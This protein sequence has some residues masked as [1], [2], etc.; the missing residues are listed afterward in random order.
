VTANAVRRLFAGRHAP[1]VALAFVLVMAA[2]C[3]LFVAVRTPA[4]EANDE[5][6]HTKNIQKLVDG[7]WYR[8]EPEAGYA[9]HQPPLYYLLA[10]G[11]QR[12]AGQAAYVAKPQQGDGLTTNGIFGHEQP[13]EKQDKRRLLP[14]RLLS[15]LLS[16]L[17]IFTTS[18]IARRLG[19]DPWTAVAAAATVAFIPRYVFSASFV[20]NDGLATLLGAV[21]TLLAVRVWQGEHE[22]KRPWR[23]PLLLGLAL[24]ALAATKLNNLPLIAVVGLAALWRLR[25]TWRA[26]A[27]LLGSAMVFSMPVF[28][29][30]QIR[31]GDPI[32]SSA[33]LRYFR[34]WIAPLV[35][36]DRSF[37]WLGKQ[38]GNG[39]VTSFWYTSGWNQF[40]WK[41]GT[42]LPFWALTLS[43]A[44]GNLRRHDRRARSGTGLC[45]LIVVA[46][47]SSV[48]ILAWNTTQY[49]AR[50]AYPA[51]GAFGAL[52]AMGWQ[53]WKVYRVV[54]FL[55][56]GLG[57]A[58]TA[59]AINADILHR[60]F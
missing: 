38:V 29:S 59:Y 15:I 39:F 30:N 42:Y 3:S 4:W 35:M 13:Q 41:I 18:R 40:R 33:S 19:G 50:L 7:E 57:F 58:M 34:S 60:Y 48:W 54:P 26:A 55:L 12:L 9:P 44:L 11:V 36:V 8:I 52:V 45:A 31:Y 17:T 43:G 27:I 37:N 32:A 21:V 6:D 56:P 1:R 25:K 16:A 2:T 28:V 49:Q 46:A 5:P 10:A 51:L 53:R 23:L 22:A 14:L 20:T 24:G 47:V